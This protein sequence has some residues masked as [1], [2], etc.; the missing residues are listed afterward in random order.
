MAY[1]VY[2]VLYTDHHAI[3]VET[4]EDQS[5]HIYHVVGNLKTGMK[6][7]DKPAKKPEDS[8]LFDSKTRIGTVTPEDYPHIKEICR[9]IPAPKI[10]FDGSTRLYPHEP[11]RGC[12]EWATEA[13]RTLIDAHIIQP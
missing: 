3:F 8:F 4:N 11:I 9:K 1:C 5:G 12:E 13:I 6:Y 10:Q 2:R 7:E